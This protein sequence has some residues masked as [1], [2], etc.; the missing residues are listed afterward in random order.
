[1]DEVLEEVYEPLEDGMLDDADLRD[2]VFTNPVRLWTSVN[3]D[4]FAGTSS[5]TPPPRSP[6]TPR[7][8]HD[9]QT[10]EN[11]RAVSRAGRILSGPH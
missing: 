10:S 4:F 8:C 9:D 11:R 2:F 1:M 7:P 6:I 5:R 3:P